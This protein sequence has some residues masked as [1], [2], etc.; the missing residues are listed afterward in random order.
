MRA[1]FDFTNAF[2]IAVESDAIGGAEL[3]LERLGA[4]QDQVEQAVGLLG[5]QDPFQRRGLA[6]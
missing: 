6:E 4:V 5:D 3:P 1:P 2:Q